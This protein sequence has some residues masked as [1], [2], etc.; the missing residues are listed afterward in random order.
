MF[1]QTM[2]NGLV[3]IVP[4]WSSNLIQIYGLGNE[5]SMPLNLILTE[6]LRSSSQNINDNIWIIIII[7]VFIILTCLKF[8]LLTDISIWN[9]NVICI[10]GK[11]LET[12]IGKTLVYCDKI[13]SIN[14]YLINNK[15]FNN[16]TI[17][18]N[19]N[20]MINNINDYK[21][22]NNIYLT[23]TRVA[24]DQQTKVLYTLWSYK[25]DL[26]VFLNNLLSE[27]KYKNKNELVLIGNENDNLLNYP[28]PI[29]AINKWISE[30]YNFP[31]LKCLK[32]GK[33]L[34][35]TTNNTTNDT[36]DKEKTVNVE[37]KNKNKET[38]EYSY[39]L[40]NI[41]DFKLDDILLTIKRDNGFVFYCL[42]STT[43]CCKE[44]V[45]NK[46]EFYSQNKSKFKNKLVLN[47]QECIYYTHNDYKKYYY[48]DYMWALNW[49]IIEI[50]K[51]QNYECNNGKY[52]MEPIE[53]FNIEDDIFLT[54]EKNS[55]PTALTRTEKNLD[56][57]VN[58][59]LQ[60]NIK[61]IKTTLNQ[62]LEKYNDYKKSIDKKHVIYHFIYNGMKNN[63]LS[64]QQKLL[65]EKNTENE[66]FETFDK[67]HN[68]HV[69]TIK[70]DIDKL[71][72]LE[73]YKRHGLKR[74]KGYLFHG[75]PGCGKTS[76]VVAMALYDERHIIEIPFSLITKHDE[77][78]KLMNLKNIN[79]T[80]INNNNI[81]IIFD[82]ID[83]GMEKITNRENKTTIDPNTAIVESI[84]KL[85]DG[86][87]T[88][89]DDAITKINLGTLLS[90]LDG[91]GNYNGLI[92]VG[93]TNCINKLDP[94]LYRELR[95]SPI[96][97][98]KLRKIDCQHIIESYF[99]QVV[100]TTLIDILK[101]NTL[102]PAKLITLCQTYDHMSVESFFK[103]I[104]INYFV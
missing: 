32:H 98:K 76:M 54:I 41:S 23:V 79:G 9:K 12:Q 5:Y 3:N 75:L 95:L 2:Y 91:I 89:P 81:I 8:G 104:L 74:K 53:L 16:I 36:N 45:E 70:K 82:E 62:I 57:D 58:Y 13:E 7:I 69:E 73:Y 65:S 38:I 92:I 29:I 40:D 72:D 49:Y 17:V 15:N 64:F 19:Y 103:K 18:N 77:F 97:F 28:L 47:G 30:N 33:Q 50:L 11:E 25:E 66:L 43:T 85:V 1:N 52:I 26:N 56:I 42:K 22:K 20:I 67:I 51:Y 21:I 10:Y 63:E 34:L 101:D 86:C 24:N 27:H 39:T 31:K 14:N 55:Q 87:L 88:N 4:F 94:A 99:D 35:E 78:D 44:W 48:S 59:T 84:G 80:E 68:E 46:I 93:T 60:S 100:D 102:T 6:I 61:N 37:N 90:K 96:E 71:K 83:I